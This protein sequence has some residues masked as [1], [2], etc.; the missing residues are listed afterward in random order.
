MK[1]ELEQFLNGARSLR[2]IE[3][4]LE[5]GKAMAVQWI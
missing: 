1:S 2:L 5:V 4:P 3:K